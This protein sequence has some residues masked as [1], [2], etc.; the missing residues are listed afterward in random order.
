MLIK[1]DENLSDTYTDQTTAHS[2]A[3]PPSQTTL[4][5]SPSSALPP[6]MLY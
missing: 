2:A 5:K 6:L 4:A 1:L 3:A